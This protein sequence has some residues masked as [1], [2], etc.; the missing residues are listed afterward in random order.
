MADKYFTNFPE[1]QY[2]LADGK[3]VYIKDFFRKSKIEQEAVNSIVEYNL[4]NIPDGDRP[5]ITAT[6]LYGN[7]NLHWTFFLVNDIENYYDWVKDSSTFERYI[8]KKYPGQYAIASSS[9]DIVA[10]KSN[11]ADVTNKFLLGEKITSVSTEGRVIEVLPE[12]NRI[13][14]DGGNFVVDE[15]ITG[16]VSTKSFTP[17]SVINHKDGVAYYKN[18]NLRKNQASSGYTSV[19]LY[20]DEYEKNEAKRRIKVIS[21]SI[22][23]NVVRRF[24]T[25]MTS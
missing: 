10:A 4:Y 15:A 9:T 5:D 6:K 13:A 19:S 3:I 12:K 21:P 16:T 8:N 25:V 17:T 20:D 7:P 2:Q 24:E 18:G 23:S 14:I 22:I 11:N 1:I